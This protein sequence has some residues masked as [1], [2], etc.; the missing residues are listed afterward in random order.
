TRFEKQLQPEQAM[1]AQAAATRLMIELCG[2]RVAEGT[3][4]VGGPGPDPVTIRLREQRVSDLLGAPISG[5]RCAEILEA[6]EFETSEAPD[7]LD[8]KPPAFR[9][10]D[11]TR[12]ADGIEEVWR[13][14]GLEKLPATLPSRPSP[15]GR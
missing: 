1:E 15:S 2:A 14:D 9:R 12:E 13:L 8:V 7:G 5:E 10:A 4:D 6:L 3:I 11:V